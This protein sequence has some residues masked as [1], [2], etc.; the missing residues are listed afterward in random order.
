MRI[1]IDTNI[2]IAALIKNSGAREV[3]LS[4]KFDLFSPE[5]V[6]EEVNKY[7]KL[8]CKKA[9]YVACYLSLK[10]EYLWTNDLDFTGIKK[11]KVINT[12]ELLNLV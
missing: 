12:G 6:I 4:G 1:L 3:I 9:P 5:L 7:K 10:C 8:I 2:I 11:V